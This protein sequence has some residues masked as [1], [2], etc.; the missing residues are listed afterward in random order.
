MNPLT[1]ND[2]WPLP[3][4]EQVREEFRKKVIEEKQHRRI[5]VG[6]YMSF[7]FEN[8]LTVKFQV[9]EILRAEKV[10]DPAHVA[11]ELDGFNTLLPKPGGLSAT[12]MLELRGSEPEVKAELTR[13]VGLDEHVHLEL[14]GARVAAE[15]D[16]GRDDGARI[17]AVQYLRFPLGPL[18][19]KLAG[20]R[21]IVLEVDHPNYRHQAELSEPQRRSL[22][23]DLES[24]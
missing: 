6:P 7:V 16:Q 19:G 4:Y 20:A 13:L 2:L 8:R 18:A 23:G 21:K 11:E 22:A 5:F 10:T 9:M 15:F 1:P 3:A 12:L 14:D 24:A 17:S